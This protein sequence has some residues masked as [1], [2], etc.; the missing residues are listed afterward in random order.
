MRTYKSKTSQDKAELLLDREVVMWDGEGVMNGETLPSG[1]EDQDYVL[2]R[3]SKGVELYNPDGLMTLDIFECL[4]ANRGNKDTIHI[5]YGGNYDIQMIL[6]AISNTKFVRNKKGKRLTGQDLIENIMEGEGYPISFRLGNHLWSVLWRPRKEFRL[7]KKGDILADGTVKEYPKGGCPSITLWEVIGYFQKPFVE[8]LTEYKVPVDEAAMANMKSGRSEFRIVDINEISR[9][10]LDEC[11]AGA[12]LFR[13]LLKYFVDA[14]IILTRFD[15]PGAGAAALYR[16][17]GVKA[18][19]A[20][21]PPEATE[22]VASAFFGGRIE[23]G[24]IGLFEH[25][26]G[27][28]I[29]SAYPAQQVELPSLI[30]QWTY[31]EGGI[32]QLQGARHLLHVKYN[33]KSGLPFYPFPYRLHGAVTFPAA[34][35]GWVWDVEYSAALTWCYR[36][37]E[38]PPTILGYWK[39]VP[40]DP[41]ARPFR[42]MNDLFNERLR[43]VDTLKTKVGPAEAIKLALN[44]SYGKLA[45]QLGGWEADPTHW[46]KNRHVSKRPGCHSQTLAGLITAGTRAELLR[47]AC[48]AKD[49][50]SI[51][52]FMTDGILSTEELQPENMLPEG[53]KKLGYWEATEPYSRVVLVMAGVY[54]L[55]KKGRWEAK[56]RGFNKNRMS[57]PDPVLDAW[58]TGDP[59]TPVSITYR[60]FFSYGSALMGQWHKRCTWEPVERF[61]ELTGDCKK[62]KPSK[63]IFHKKNVRLA[64]KENTF[65]H[66]TG[67]ES[68]PFEHIRML[69]VPKEEKIRLQEDDDTKEW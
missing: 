52:A 67:A 37:G 59:S 55:E 44:S 17:Q 57:V 22:A 45:Q 12:E 5:T 21:E 51:L 33:F 54:W 16:Q 7:C 14:N 26:Y 42:Y 47:L 20:D 64:V 50:N 30:G 32:T 62:R 31:H 58:S 56:S 60:R 19:I 28:D 34:G 49:P 23:V 66:E 3:N 8:A 43:L 48:T 41:S 1:Y 69:D 4:L 53:Q 10:C 2:L 36:F 9:Y 39:F 24:A 25:V 63:D 6:R 13:K 38:K 40:T 46:D 15:G 35:K 27:Y 68:A 18:F 11:V 65:Y 29:T 61:L